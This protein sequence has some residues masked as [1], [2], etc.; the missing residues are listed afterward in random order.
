M[1]FIIVTPE[2]LMMYDQHGLFKRDVV[3]IGVLNIRTISIEKDKFLYSLFDNG[4]IIVLSE[5]NVEYGKVTL[6]RVPR[7]EKRRN[8]IANII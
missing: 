1:D 4:D 6:R 2:S 7:P 8:Q 5:S 3:T